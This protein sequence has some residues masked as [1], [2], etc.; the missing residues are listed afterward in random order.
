MTRNES[1]LRLA[2]SAHALQTRKTD[3]SPYV[4]HPIM[5]AQ[6]LTAYDVSE[7]VIVAAL[8]HD[9]LED[10]KVTAAEVKA[11]GGETVLHIVEAVSENKNLPWEE[12]KEAYVH[13]VVA[14]GESV[15]L[16][17]VADKIHNAESLL[18]HI[19]VAGDEAWSVFNRGKESKL[20]FEN[21]LYTELT[22]V[23]QHPLLD[24][25]GSIIKALETS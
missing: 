14:G 10:T 21:R 19:A 18:D 11:E 9:V 6:L 20:W 25:Y 23:W 7:D 16:V 15:W 8:L 5:V 13:T 1:A 2:M 3:N 4:I 12:R 24:R 17:S 22:K